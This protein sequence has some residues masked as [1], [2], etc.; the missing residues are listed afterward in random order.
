MPL[1]AWHGKN[2]GLKDIAIFRRCCHRRHPCFTNT[3]L[4]YIVTLTFKF[5]LHL[6]NFN[7]GCYLVI[8]L[9]GGHC[10]LLTTL[11]TSN[12]AIF[13]D[14]FPLNV[15]ELVKKEITRSGDPHKLMASADV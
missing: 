14:Q 4:V 10:C 8:L 12:N 15:L 6:K 3:C 5:D 9:P 11:I 13:S 7:L 1:W 2:L